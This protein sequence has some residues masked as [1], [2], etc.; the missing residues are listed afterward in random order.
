MNI[1]YHHRTKS[2]DG[3]AVHIR[4]LIAALRER[5]HAVEE[6][7]LSAGDQGEMGSEGGWFGRLAARAPRVLYE[8]AEHAYGPMTAGRLARAGRQVGAD[9]L[10]ERHALG[11]TAGVR[12]ARRLGIPMLLEVNSPLA[13][14]RATHEQL[15]LKRWARRSER[16]VLQRADRVLCVT[17]VLADMLDEA[18]VPRSRL[19]VVRNGVDL[20]RYPSPGPRADDG[21]VVIGFT[22]FFRPWHGIEDLVDALSDGSLPAG[23]RL[24]LVG[25]GPSRE[26]IEARAR[27]RGVADRVEITGAV[28]HERIP[29]HLRA[30]DVCVQPAAT[31]WASPLKLPEYMAAARSIVAPDQANLREVLTHERDALLF[32]PTA[33]GAM[34]RAVATLAHDRALRERLGAAARETVEREKMTW[35]GNAERVEAIASGCLAERETRRVP[36]AASGSAPHEQPPKQPAERPS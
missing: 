12:A 31:A 10:Y 27:E 4:E 1:L 5:G 14:E 33:R 3:Q 15:V 16:S 13:H 11:N 18:G 19:H 23:A 21:Q 25:D 17:Q 26:S 35:A 20:L 7:A 28:A 34:A 8:I 36:G 2:R 32:D 6:W 30:M 24:L 9:V 29:E 22:G